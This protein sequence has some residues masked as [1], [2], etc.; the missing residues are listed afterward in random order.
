M[1][2]RPGSRRTKPLL[3]YGR[4]RAGFIEISASCQSCAECRDAECCALRKACDAGWNGKRSN[5]RFDG[6]PASRL[7]NRMR[8]KQREGAA[9]FKLTVRLP[10]SLIERAKIRA[11]KDKL[12]MQDL[13][14]EAIEAYL[15]TSA[16]RGGESR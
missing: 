4:N 10:D 12:T 7:P 9:M 8:T 16:K 14:T 13:V 11:I 2:M 1:K 6:K 5:C 3:S 15:K